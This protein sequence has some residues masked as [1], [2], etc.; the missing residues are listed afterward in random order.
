MCNIMGELTRVCSIFFFRLLF[1]L[2]LL[3]LLCLSF[4]SRSHF[5][6]RFAIRLCMCVCVC[7]GSMLLTATSFIRLTVQQIDCRLRERERE[8]TMRMRRLLRYLVC[9]RVCLS[10]SILSNTLR[11]KKKKTPT[12][13]IRKSPSK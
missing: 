9:I 2:L 12:C 7:A 13:E 4:I 11:K 3:R 1:F 8:R 6:Y 5:I 10:T